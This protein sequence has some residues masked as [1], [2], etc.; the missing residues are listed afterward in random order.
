M[1]T[2]VLRRSVFRSS[3]NRGLLQLTSSSCYSCKLCYDSIEINTNQLKRV[4]SSAAT[5][6]LEEVSTY[7]RGRKKLA[8][9]M[10]V[11]QS[12]AD[13]EASQVALSNSII[14]YSL[15]TPC[16]M[17]LG[18]YFQQACQQKMPDPSLK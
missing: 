17:L 11:E 4:S 10:G 16:S 18:T 7:N 14:L 15:V 13:V 3:V 1:Y 6:E 2:A 9:I 5:V 12:E 8:Q